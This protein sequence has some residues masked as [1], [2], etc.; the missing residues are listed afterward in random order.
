MVFSWRALVLD[1]F[2]GNVN[3]LTRAQGVLNPSRASPGFQLPLY[4]PAWVDLFCLWPGELEVVEN[5][6][7][8]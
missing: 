6:C 8:G 5:D 2:E 4:M 3:E 1:S 7:T